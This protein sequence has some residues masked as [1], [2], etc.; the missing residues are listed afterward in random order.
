[1]SDKNDARSIPLLGGTSISE[2]ESY[3]IGLFCD[4]VEWIAELNMI[5][6]GKLEGSHYAAMRQLRDSLRTKN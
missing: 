1:M 5:K 3:V 4:E 6:T 2:R